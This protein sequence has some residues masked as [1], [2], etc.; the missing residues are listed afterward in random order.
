MDLRKAVKDTRELVR[1]ARH[2]R[3]NGIDEE[4]AVDLVQDALALVKDIVG[5]A[6]LSAGAKAI[7]KA[8]AQEA[9]KHLDEKEEGT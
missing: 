7:L 5:D 1:S 4:E 2:A 6:K 9:L 3:P 8:A